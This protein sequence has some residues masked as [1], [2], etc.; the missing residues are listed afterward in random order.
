MP[1]DWATELSSTPDLE[2]RQLVEKLRVLATMAAVHRAA[3]DSTRDPIAEL[4]PETVQTSWG[5]LK[6]R[7]TIGKGSFGTVHLAWD[8]GLEREVALKILHRSPRSAS[9]IREGR[10]LA[11]IRH[12]NVVNVYGVDEFDDAVGLWME[13][14]DGLTLKQ[15]LQQ[16]GVFGAYETALIGTDLCRAV[17]AV[18]KA[19]LVHRDIKAQNVMREAGG[20]IVLMDFGAGEVRGRQGDPLRRPTGT[21]LYL[22]PEVLGG[23]PATAVSDIYSIGVLLYHLLTM[24]YPVEGSTIAELE[25]AHASR[26]ATPISDL[27]PDLPAGVVQVIERALDPDPARRP[28]SAGAMQQELLATIAPAPSP[29][30]SDGSVPSA[31][32]LVADLTADTSARDRTRDLARSG[33]RRLRETRWLKIAAAAAVLVGVFAVPIA[34]SYRDRLGRTM[35]G[36]LLPDKKIVVVLPFRVIGANKEEGLY[37]EGVSVVLTSNLAQ[38]GLPDLQ[39]MPSTEVREAR[40]DTV[41]KAKAEFGAT[42]VLSGVVQFSG[43][44]VRA[45][46]SLIRTADRRELIGRSTTLAAGDPFALQ[47]VVT[48]DVLTMLE[49]GL[50]QGTPREPRQVFGTRDDR[51]FFLYTQARGAMQNYHEQ[52]NVD[53]AIRLLNEA[54][55]RDPQ[56]AIAYAALGRAS[57]ENFSTLKQAVWLDRAGEACETSASLNPQ[58]SEAQLCLGLVNESRGEYEQAIESYRR[59]IDYSPGNDDAHRALGSVLD[60]LERV[61]EAEAAYLRAIELRPGYWA[62]YARIAQFY[63][64]RNDYQKA[65][66]YYERALTLSPDNARV[67]FSLGLVFTNKGQYDRG[68]EYLE[69]AIRLRPYLAP[70]YNN[71]GLAYLRARRYNDAVVPLERAFSVLGDY[72]TAGNLAR[73]YWLTGRKDEARQKY[74][75]GIRDGEEQLQMNPRDHGIHLLVGRYYAMLGRKSD[76]LR[77]LDVALLLHPGDAH[78]LTIAATSHVVLGD[79]SRA[80]SLMEAAA[81]LGYTA[82][83]FL[84]EPELDA[85]KTEPRYAAVMSANGPGR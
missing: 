33:W 65:G 76:S 35:T 60:K 50:P 12:P 59:A 56:Y 5:P 19:G 57:W 21:P 46:Y 32:R 84:G 23:Q 82:A 67:L 45:S 43:G 26:R 55:A 25:S 70:P 34:W 68:V 64:L 42:L 27:R 52:E 4:E 24:R 85:L 40:I 18:H 71:L 16:R 20:R 15:T 7:R 74:E 61:D 11:S 58:L 79:R 30:H 47:D 73:I 36:M 51:A 83:Q 63:N 37:S 9:V 10:L 80:L 1:V 22:A 14:V 77:H 38:L 41:E 69:R 17:A 8:P 2:M 6:L 81:R 13:L 44:Q 49:P 54:V 62:G 29:G 39:V 48:R 66:D 53:A 75:F 72:R 28:R 3:D 31:I 78:Y